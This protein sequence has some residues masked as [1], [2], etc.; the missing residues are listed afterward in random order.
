MLRRANK[1]P[2]NDEEVHVQREHKAVKRQ[3]S[4]KTVLGESDEKSESEKV[5]EKLVLGAEDEILDSLELASEKKVRFTRS[6]KSLFY[7]CMKNVLDNH[8]CSLSAW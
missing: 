4:R 7:I 8:G 1:R 6:G 2:Q 3:K 5:L